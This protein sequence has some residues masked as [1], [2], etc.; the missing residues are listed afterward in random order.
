MF[1]PI[2]EVLPDIPA[3]Q[4]NLLMPSSSIFPAR[5]RAHSRYANRSGRISAFDSSAAVSADR[6]AHANQRRFAFEP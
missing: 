4:A 5:P 3:A 2:T 6:Y 1:T